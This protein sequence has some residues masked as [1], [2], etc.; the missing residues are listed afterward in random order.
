MWYSAYAIGIILIPAVILHSF[1]SRIAAVVLTGLA[2]VAVFMALLRS[3]MMGF[4]TSD[5]AIDILYM[6]LPFFLLYLGIKA[7]WAT[8]IYHNFKGKTTVATS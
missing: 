8:S 7:I 3:P 5:V 1:H 6:V 4:G 2:L